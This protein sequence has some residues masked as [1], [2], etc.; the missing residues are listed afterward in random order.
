M[1]D[2]IQEN[3]EALI[4]KNPKLYEEFERMTLE[5]IRQGFRSYSASA[6][7]EVMRWRSDLREGPDSRL[8]LNNN[9]RSRLAR[10]FEDR[11]PEY[12]GFFRLRKLH[13]ES[14]DSTHRADEYFREYSDAAE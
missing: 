14:V 4:E 1:T 9:Y 10:M 12:A 6:I 8:K 13:D 7:V 2:R 5:V 3:F 11:N